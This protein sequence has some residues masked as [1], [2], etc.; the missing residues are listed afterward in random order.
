M[1]KFISILAAA[2]LLLTFAACTISP[3]APASP[4]AEPEPTVGIP[5]P[6]TEYGSLAEINEL[7]GVNLVHPP[8]MG[9]TDERFSVINGEYKLAQY[10][11][12]VA[13]VDYCFRA[14]PFLD[15]DISGY[16]V[17]GG[18]V[19]SGRPTEELEFVTFKTGEDYDAP[20]LARWEAGDVQYVL[21]S[22]NASDAFED[23]AEELAGLTRPWMTEGE[24]AAYYESLEGEYQDEYSQRA[25]MKGEAKGSGGVVF[26]VRWAG[27]AFEDYEWVMTCRLCEDGLL[28]YDDCVQTLY[29]TDTQGKT[30]SEV[31]GTGGSGFF[32]PTEDGKLLWD[33][34]EDDYCRECI[35]FKP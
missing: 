31:L 15:D 33:G 19:F 13:G 2:V 11:F 10:D 28:S 26:T 22:R 9:V 3:V 4:S 8:V 20:K 35:F 27:S 34:A 5:N 30:S 25:H 14:S 32:T 18:L 23:V 7:V 16:Y 6:I 29:K 17:D 21:S 12:T 1:K 24:L